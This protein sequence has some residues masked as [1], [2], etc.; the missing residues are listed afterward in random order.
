M[1]VHV[2]PFFSLAGKGAYQLE[3]LDHKNPS[4]CLGSSEGHNCQ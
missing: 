4:I 1:M 2:H 3:F